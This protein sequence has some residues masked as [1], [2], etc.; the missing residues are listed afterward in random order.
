MGKNNG[1]IE[2]E[3]A[4]L[5]PVFVYYYYE[6]RSTSN[7]SRCVRVYAMHPICVARLRSRYARFECVDFE[8]EHEQSY[9]AAYDIIAGLWLWSMV[10]LASHSPFGLFDRIPLIENWNCRF[11]V[12][13]FE[14]IY[15]FFSRFCELF[16]RWLMCGC[17]S[18]GLMP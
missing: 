5:G 11:R 6:R 2:S 7:T 3:L 17:R 4:W 14:S 16:F 12:I 13:E 15:V 8:L 1:G 18:G 10:V 9:Y